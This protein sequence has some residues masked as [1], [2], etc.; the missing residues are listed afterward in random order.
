MNKVHQR[1]PR[2][3]DD[4]PKIMNLQRDDTNRLANATKYHVQVFIDDF[5]NAGFEMDVA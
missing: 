3:L 5:T 1:T 2:T 4:R